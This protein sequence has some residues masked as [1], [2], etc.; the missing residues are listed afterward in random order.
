[1]SGSTQTTDTQSQSVSQVP[2]WVQNAGQ[3]NYAYAQDVASRPLQQYQGQMVADV[4]PQTQQAWNTAANSGNVGMDQYNA[5]TAGYL[6]ALGQTPASV[7][8]GQL[9]NTNLQP[10][11]N[12]YTQSVINTTLPIMQQNLGLQQ[13]QQANAANSANAF[14]GSRQGVQA[15]VTQAQGA[16]GMGQ[17]AAQLNQANFGQ[18]QTA[19]Q[20]DIAGRLQA[21]TSNQQAQQ[22]KTNSDILASQGLNNTGDSLLKQN[23]AN[24]AMQTSAGGSQ[25]QQA[26]NQINAQMSKFAQA[27]AYPQQQL[28]TLLSALGMSQGTQ[29]SMTSGD[30]QSQTTTP[31]NWGALALGGLNT[32]G[33]LFSPTGALGAMNPMGSDREMKTDIT[34][35]GKDPATGIPL[36]AY[37]YKGDPKSYPKVVGPMAQDVQK[38]VPGAVKRLGGKL[39][40]HPA[41]MGALTGQDTV[42]AMLSPGEAVLT[43]EGADHIGRDKIA[44]A[45]KKGV[46]HY[47]A[48]TA[49]VGP[50][51]SLGTNP[52]IPF[53]PR[54]GAPGAPDFTL[55]RSSFMPG[56]RGVGAALTNPRAGAKGFPGALSNTKLRAPKVMGALA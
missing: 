35:V 14:G 30:S 49:F 13:N 4:S 28:A 33:G 53:K 48:G 55:G 42:P 52:I 54:R 6:G 3:Q 43:P 16:M 8:A 41:V 45:N 38:V 24:Y 25:Q 34:P 19:A 26:Q 21:A 2:Q 51:L 31:T 50:D 36:H 32:L 40:V 10:Y 29:P 20:Q 9:S 11:M 39:T 15:G 17:M 44:A 12:P 22:A 56:V 5:A 46:R 47:A 23:A 18:A 27:N 7:T 37:R 1:M